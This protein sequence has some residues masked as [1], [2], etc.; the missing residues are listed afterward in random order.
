MLNKR[1]AGRM[2]RPTFHIAFSFVHDKRIASTPAF[3]VTDYSDSLD[4][5]IAFK[6]AT[7]FTFACVLVLRNWVSECRKENSMY[8]PDEK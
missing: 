7:Q 3:F 4:S 5:A 1:Q 2:E 6:F 8:L